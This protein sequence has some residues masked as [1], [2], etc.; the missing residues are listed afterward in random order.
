[1]RDP[2][3]LAPLHGPVKA[4]RVLAAVHLGATR[5]IDNVPVPLDK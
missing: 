5:L 2:D 3:T 4:A 1:V